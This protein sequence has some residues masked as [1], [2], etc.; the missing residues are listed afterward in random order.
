MRVNVMLVH[1]GADDKSVVPFGHT[2]ATL[3]VQNGV[4]IKTVSNI[5][6]YYSAGFTLDT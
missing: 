5:L 3:A 1:M 2:Y 6:G 4:D